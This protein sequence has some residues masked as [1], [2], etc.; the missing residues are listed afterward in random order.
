[1]TSR[2]LALAYCQALEN[3]STWGRCVWSRACVHIGVG[4]VQHTFVL[5]G[6][7]GAGKGRL[8]AEHVAAVLLVT[9]GQVMLLPA[10]VQDS[11]SSSLGLLLLGRVVGVQTLG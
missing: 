7:L 5:S 3:W 8:C 6:A 9:L 11:D 4:A 10:V 1:M 2:R